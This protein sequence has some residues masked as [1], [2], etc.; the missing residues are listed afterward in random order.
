MTSLN[1]T[2]LSTEQRSVWFTSPL[3]DTGP[4]IRLLYLVLWLLPILLLSHSLWQR[5]TLPPDLLRLLALALLGYYL[6]QGLH[7]LCDKIYPF[8]PLYTRSRRA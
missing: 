5:Q 6:A 1:F 4:T 2:P 7:L 3:G 8:A